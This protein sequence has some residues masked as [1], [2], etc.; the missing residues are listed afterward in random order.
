MAH[1]C[2]NCGRGFEDGST[3]MLS[4]CP[5][6]GGNRFQYRPAGT[7]GSQEERDPEPEMIEA[8]VDPEYF[9]KQRQKAQED[10][11]QA[12]ARATI[13]PPDQLPRRSEGSRSVPPEPEQVEEPAE[14]DP[15]PGLEELREQLDD[16]FESIKIVDR[17]EYELN[18]MELYERRECIIELQENGRYV[19]EVPETLTDG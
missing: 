19:I 6:C 2:T 8:D 5:E 18:L 11:A 1:E 17:G 12:A 16:R 3:D 13:V 7:R 9:E 14:T 15:A 10:R 4:G